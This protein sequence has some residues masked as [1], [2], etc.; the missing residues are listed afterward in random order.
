[1]VV[2]NI[3]PDKYKSQEDSSLV[4]NTLKGDNFAFNELFSRYEKPLKNMLTKRGAAHIS[5]DI[6]QDSFIKAFINLDK[7]N[8]AYEFRQWIYTIA[9]RLHI[10]H[11]RKTKTETLQLD[12]ISTP[13]TAPNPEQSIIEN[14]LR[15][16]LKDTIGRLPPIYKEVIELRFLDELSYEEIT[17]K[18]NIPL[19][20]VKTHIYRAKALLME[21]QLLKNSHFQLENNE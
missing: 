1:M 17:H 9:I 8:P 18:L 11:T 20:T 4:E 10:D 13:S 21:V 16:Q 7:Y 5:G 12:S 6:V 2:K 19:G 15:A 14:Q 3:G